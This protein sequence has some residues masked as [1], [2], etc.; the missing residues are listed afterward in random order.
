MKRTDDEAD[1]DA[2]THNVASGYARGYCLDKD[3]IECRQLYK[4]KSQESP[5]ET[6][7]DTNW[8]LALAKSG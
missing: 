1:D 5:S 3:A 6:L 4:Y 7:K 8:R 2:E